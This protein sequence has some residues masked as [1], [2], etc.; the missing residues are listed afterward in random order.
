M[1]G[2]VAPI[3]DIYFSAEKLCQPFVIFD[4]DNT[5]IQDEGYTHAPA[6]L[7]WR[8][9]ALELLAQL[10]ESQVACFIAT[11]QSG[12]ARG[13]FTREQLLEFHTALVTSVEAAGGC[14]RA[15]C[16]CPHMDDG[17]VPEFSVACGCRK[18]RPG[19]FLTL[20]REFGLDPRRGVSVGDKASDW[21]AAKMAG[22]PA[23]DSRPPIDRWSNSIFEWWS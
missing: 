14:I 11:N 15:I 13:I 16:T 19:L 4:R 3:L 7:R 10:N 6:D 1:S 2:L 17:A 18:P 23:I 5:L 12:L 21:E 8:Q 9:G 22:L 20:L